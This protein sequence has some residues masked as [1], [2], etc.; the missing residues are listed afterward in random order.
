MLTNKL[1]T[2]KES[3]VNLYT[4]HHINYFFDKYVKRSFDQ[5]DV[6][7]FIVLIRDYTP[8]LSIFRELGDFLAHPDQK[9]RGMVTNN[10]KPVTSYFEKKTEYVM[11]GGKIPMKRPTGL[12]VLEEVQLSLGEIFRS[13]EIEGFVNDRDDPSFRDFVFCLIFM[14]SNFRLKIKNQIIDMKVKYGNALSLSI[15]YESSKFERNYISLT[16]LCLNGV[17]VTCP[18][19][20]TEELT[21]YIVRRFSN[22]LLGAIAYEIDTNDLSTDME[23]LSTGQVWLLPDR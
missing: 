15:S 7:L 3:Y 9:D 13:V 19:G 21:G 6:A 11:D 2:G 1:L 17:W 18:S 10:F 12:A 22:G 20:V 14:L 8:E 5:D 16:V 23:Q 4:R